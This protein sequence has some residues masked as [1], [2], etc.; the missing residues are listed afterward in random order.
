MIR[1]AIVKLI[2]RQSLEEEEAKEVMGQITAGQATP[3]QIGAFLTALRMK[4][5]T[6][7]EITGFAKAIRLSAAPVRPQRTDL[8]D[9]CGTGGDRAGTFN[10]STTAAFVAAGA[11]LAVAKHVDYS[12]SS[13]CGSAD[14]LQALGVNL[15]LTPQQTAR[16]I[17]EVN[18]GFLFA[19]RLH[20]AL[21]HAAAARQEIGVRTVFDILGPLVNPASA[22]A[23][24]VGVYAGALTEL[25]ARVLHSLGSRSAFVVYGADGLD[26]LS[27]TGVNKVS[28]LGEDGITTFALDSLELDLPRATLSEL[29]G[30]TPQENLAIT[31]DILRGQKGPKR[32][33]VLLNAAA[34]LVVGGK[35]NSL[36]E[37]IALAAQAIDSGKA[38]EK[39]EQLNAFS[40]K[41][42]PES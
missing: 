15:N 3:A 41:A 42:Q 6:V 33:I 7:A 30:G 9:I 5:E 22:S 40:Q 31:R 21:H 14:L 4:G 37:A 23:R 12:V 11:G 19:P 2:D 38:L 29:Q 26:E 16:C 39:L 10:I 34:A 27:T 8:V 18:L 17:D 24:V 25:V 36:R 32:D 1:E 28:R 35:A 13:Q 20:P